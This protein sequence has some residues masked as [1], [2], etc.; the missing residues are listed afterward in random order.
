MKNA[1]AYTILIADAKGYRKIWKRK[2][3]WDDNIKMILIESECEI[4]NEFRKVSGS[5]L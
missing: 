5:E 4:V 2:R 1:K 3:R